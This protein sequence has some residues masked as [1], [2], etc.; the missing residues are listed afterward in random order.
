[1]NFTLPT[2]SS[3]NF[4]GFFST[5][6]FVVFFLPPTPTPTPLSEHQMHY[7]NPSKVAGLIDKT[8]F[9]FYA[10]TTLR[11]HDVGMMTIGDPT[12]SLFGM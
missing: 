3:V 8:A 4:D 7:N 5:K 11:K 1:M 9:R 12:V 6:V 10:T 2:C